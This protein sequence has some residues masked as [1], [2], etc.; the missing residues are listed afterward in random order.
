M[1]KKLISGALAVLV[2][3]GCVTMGSAGSQSDPLVSLSYLT[4]TFFAGLKDYVAQWVAQ[5]TRDLG[6]ASADGWIT[7]SGF[8]PG[9]GKY[10]GTITLTTGSGLIW[11]SGSGA[12]SSGALV[13]A[14][15]GTE[16]AAGKALTAGHRYLAGADTVVA[17]SSQSAQWMAE[18]KWR[19]GS[20]G[21]VT[22]PLLFTDVLEN[23]WF[24]DDV[25]FVVE[26]GL[27]TGVSD[28]LFRPGNT[29]E[30]G[31][32][33]TV[34]HRLAKEPAVGYSPE[35][36][37]VPDGQWYTKGII[38]CA[39]TGV[40]NGVGGGR[41]APGQAIAR[42]EIAVMLYNY[43]VK[44]GHSAGE[45]GNLNAFS[46]AG[47]VASWAKDAVSWAVGAGILNGSGGKLL[48]GSG[49]ERAQVAAMLHR[50]HTWL[51]AR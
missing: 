8:V 18:G 6:Q 5:D 36:T 9:E 2:L 10:G 4:G 24:Y 39:Q 26:N 32:M 44:T 49:A 47:S 22:A 33:A 19:V 46:D 41:F 1:K 20:G 12:V 11:I 23:Q 50:F 42:Q 34:L 38:W 15:V 27:F 31:M 30:R 48:P 29:M 28:T 45:R 13:D 7:S 3:L 16:L 35:Y 17:V 25:R 43:A 37:D 51:E 40:V 14:T 21:T